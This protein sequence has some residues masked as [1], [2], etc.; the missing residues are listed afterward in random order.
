VIAD[1]LPDAVA[2]VEMFHD[3]P[4]LRLLPEEEAVLGTVADKRR[5][6]FT[7]TRGCA[8]QA[9]ARLGLP[10]SPIVPGTGRAPQWPTGV[11]GSITH[12]AGYRACALARASNFAAIGVDAEP[13]A[14]LPDGLIADIALPDERVRL[15]ELSRAQPAVHWDR[16]LFSAKESI[17]KAWFPLTGQRPGFADATVRIDRVGACF[18]ARLTA[19]GAP[20]ELAGRFAVRDG[21]VATAV[22][23]PA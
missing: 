4:D 16:L 1:L 5:R 21:I 7:T 6:E 14:P 17:Y 8:R 2:A 18:S 3:P 9:L 15:D 20:T 22:A 11:V 13:D 10:A 19:D 23:L 12:C